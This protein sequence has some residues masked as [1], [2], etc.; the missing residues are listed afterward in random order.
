MYAKGVEFVQ[1]AT[2]C[3]GT[4]VWFLICNIL[5]IQPIPMCHIS[6]EREQ[7]PDEMYHLLFMG[8]DSIGRVYDQIN[9]LVSSFLL[10]HTVDSNR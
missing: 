1:C 8:R 2:F 7:I 5:N 10:L 6:N 3:C 4:F 9:V